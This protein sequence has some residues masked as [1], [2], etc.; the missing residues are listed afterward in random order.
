MIVDTSVLVNAILRMKLWSST[1]FTLLI[2]ESVECRMSAVGFVEL[3]IV[4]ESRIGPSAAPR[5][6]AFLFRSGIG[7]EP[8][9][10]W[11]T[12]AFRA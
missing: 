9:T 5:I 3:L 11:K 2:Q 8:V 6:G 7:V 10:I 12:G 4:M 1:N